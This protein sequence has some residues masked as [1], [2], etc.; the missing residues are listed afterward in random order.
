MEQKKTEAKIEVRVVDGKYGVFSRAGR[1][2]SKLYD[3]HGEA[4]KRMHQIVHFVN[5]K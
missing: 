2:I 1:L 3:T 4:H 5:R